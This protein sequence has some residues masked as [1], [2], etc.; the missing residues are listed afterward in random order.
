M[1]CVIVD[2]YLPVYHNKK[3]IPD[4]G[5]VFRESYLFV[6]YVLACMGGRVYVGIVHKK[7]IRSKLEG[8]FAGSGSFFTRECHPTGILFVHPA[9]NVY[10]ALFAEYEPSS[11]FRLGGWTQT[12]TQLSPLNSLMIERGHRL[13][14]NKC[15]RCGSSSH[16]ATKCTSEPWGRGYKCGECRATVRI[17][18]DGASATTPCPSTAKHMAQPTELSPQRNVVSFPAGQPARKVA[19]MDAKVAK[20]DV[21]ATFA[22]VSVC[23]VEY[24]ALA[25]YLWKTD[26][27][28]RGLSIT[29]TR[30]AEH[31]VGFKG[32]GTKTL[33]GFAS[34]TSPKELLPGPKL[35]AGERLVRLSSSWSKTA[36]H[37]VE[38]CKPGSSSTVCPGLRMGCHTHQHR[39]THTQRTPP[40]EC[41]NTGEWWGRW[42][43]M[44]LNKNPRP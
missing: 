3:L 6:M 28:P 29:M 30:C 4:L 2:D 32:G 42:Y 44:P 24:T 39:R 1:V 16:R 9:A 15:F 40:P 31:R 18:S 34:S 22:R 21:K 7:W 35:R 27:T 20:I 11:V 38:L 13:L 17:M 33:Q 25:W 5:F 19:K 14:N 36:R 23:A 37:N 26:P 12:G 10:F 8:R 43:D 41:L